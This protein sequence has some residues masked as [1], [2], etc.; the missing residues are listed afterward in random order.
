MDEKIIRDTLDVCQHTIASSQKLD[1][2]NWWLWIAGIE[3][4]LILFLIF[5][6]NNSPQIKNEKQRFKEESMKKDVDFNNIIHSSFHANELYDKLKI[7]CHP[8][9]FPT[10]QVQN[11]IAENIFQEIEKNKTNFKKLLELKQ[12]AESKLDIKI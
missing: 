5:K 3:F 7:K 6:R 10:N 1:D 12:E 8:D 4:I 11:E 2:I 9:R